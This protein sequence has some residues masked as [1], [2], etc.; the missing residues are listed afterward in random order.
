MNIEDTLLPIEYSAESGENGAGGP[1][2]IPLPPPREILR[3][4]LENARNFW[5]DWFKGSKGGKNAINHSLNRENAFVQN[6]PGPA[7][8]SQPP[9]TG[10]GQA[11]SPPVGL[12][13][14]HGKQ[15]HDLTVSQGESQIEKV[16]N[17]GDLAEN[18]GVDI[19]QK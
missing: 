10:K 8:P 3:Y 15:R 11:S 2:P 5:A 14:L 13:V 4:S 19:G 1:E 16:G 18:F 7:P 9:T 12:G 17:F 6:I